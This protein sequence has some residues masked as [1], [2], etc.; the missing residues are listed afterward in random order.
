VFALSR[1]SDVAALK[2]VSQNLMHQSLSVTDGVYGVLSDRDVAGQIARLGNETRD[3][4][5]SE[6]RTLTELMT[7]YVRELEVQR[8]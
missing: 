1:A 2:A 5:P 6:L 8:S 4:S 3:L 7:K